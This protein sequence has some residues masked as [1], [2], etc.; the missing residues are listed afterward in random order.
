MSNPIKVLLQRALRRHVE[1][2]ELKP[3]PFC[4]E[5]PNCFQV[6]DDRYVEGEMN[7]VVECKDMGCIFRRSSPDRSLE[8][9]IAGWNKRTGFWWLD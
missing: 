7:W 2:N 5:Q 6:R 9:L 1:E 3:C 8:R 4:G